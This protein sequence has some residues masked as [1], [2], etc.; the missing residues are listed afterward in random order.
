MPI[1]GDEEETK[2]GR[3]DAVTSTVPQQCW[4]ATFP[5]DLLAVVYRRISSSR[6]RIR[7]A[8]VC[9]SWRA[10]II[11][12]GPLPTLPW[13]LLSPRDGNRKKPMF[14]RRGR[15]LTGPEQGGE[16]VDYR[17]PGRRVARNRQRQG[18]T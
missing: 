9:R 3:G 18:Q 4:S 14:S 13:L 7:F 1:V 11:S 6:G 16:K 12:I 10:A 15:A 17:R 2:R 5:D 8:A